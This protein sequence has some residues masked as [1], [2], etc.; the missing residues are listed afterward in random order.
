MKRDWV[1]PLALVTLAGAVLRLMLLGHQSFW[2]DE[3]VSMR[4]AQSPLGDIVRGRARDLGN[5]PFHLIV[6]HCWG[7]LFGMSDA[8]LRASSALF[9]VLSIP[10]VFSVGRR[11]IGE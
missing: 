8:A 11:L 2:Y 3:V 9:G 5:P 1:L 6:L 10:A 4:L 7:K